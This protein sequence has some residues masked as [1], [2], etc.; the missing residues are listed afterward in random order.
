MFSQ[1]LLGYAAAVLP[2]ARVLVVGAGL[3]GLAATE[4]LLDAGARVTVIDSF[5]VPGGRTASFA[6]KTEVAG[7]APG[8]LVEHGLHAWFQHYHALYGLMA[9]AGVPKPPFTSDGVC[10]WNEARGHF[11][12]DGGPLF[13][14]L[15]AL[16]L[17][18]DIRGP[19]AS[20]LVAFAKL[21]RDLP[22]L[23]RAT[24]ATDRLSAAA[25]LDQYGVP[26]AAVEQVLARCMFSLT[27]LALH[28]LSALEL[29]RWMSSILPD[30]RIRCLEGGGTQAMCAPIT[31]SLRARGADFRFGVELQALRL[32]ED[33]RVEL[34]LATA[35]D[36]TGVRHLLVPGFRPDQAP[37]PSHF[38]AIVCTLPWERLLELVQ[39]D[40]ALM[41]RD[42]FARLRALRNVHPLSLR[43]WFERPIERAEEHYI[44]AAGTLFDVVRPTREPERQRGIKLIDALIENVETHL[45]GFAYRG[46]RFMPEGPE[47]Q[48]I[49]DEVIADL[50]RMYPGRI[51]A[52]RVLRRFV[53]VREGVVAARPGAWLNRAPQHV[54]LRDFVLAGDWTRQPWGVCMEGAVR[55][56]QLA[57]A[58]LLRDAPVEPEAPAF[59]Q[60]AYS[61]RSLFERT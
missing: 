9:R 53:H 45:P 5:P 43:L 17:P 61:L 1:G 30:P 10:L 31:D 38:D 56:G 35:H 59:A 39:Q 18:E 26:R 54:G 15:N 11:Q 34:T 2:S 57:V 19:R 50:E 44:L 3:A 51:R 13:W 25:L 55:S 4:R 48:A 28:E 41:A 29:L 16:R 36:R 40:E 49:V 33:N 46:E 24:E 6:I 47:Q 42:A 32:R 7:L 8:D 14:L 20:A 12:I 52:N 21:I 60:T 23:L 27:S 37:D 58:A 22:A